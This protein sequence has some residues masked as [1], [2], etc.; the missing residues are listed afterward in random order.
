MKLICIDTKEYT[1][2]TLGKCYDSFDNGKS[3]EIHCWIIKFENF[4]F[5][6]IDDSGNVR[7]INKNCFITLEEYRNQKI[8]SI[9]LK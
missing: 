6:I 1:N 5:S 2:I 9:L 8:E 3:M 4:I 7:G